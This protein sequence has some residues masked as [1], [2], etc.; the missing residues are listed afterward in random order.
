MDHLRTPVDIRTLEVLKVHGR[1]ES[2]VWKRLHSDFKELTFRNIFY[3]E[4]RSVKCWMISWSCNKHDIN[5]C[6]LRE[7]IDSVCTTAETMGCHYNGH[8]TARHEHLASQR[9]P[10]AVVRFLIYFDLIINDRGGVFIPSAAASE[11]SQ[12]E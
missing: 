12:Q 10:E 9:Y 3:A 2:Q 4:Q 5:R 6:R 8:S 11:Q 7:L 1:C